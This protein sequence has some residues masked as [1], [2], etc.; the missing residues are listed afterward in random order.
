MVQ[1]QFTCVLLSWFF[2]KV[3]CHKLPHIGPFRWLQTK[4]RWAKVS[5]TGKYSQS[6]LIW[7]KT[8]FL[9]CW[10]PTIWG[11]SNIP[12]LKDILLLTGPLTTLMHWWGMDFLAR[13]A[14]FEAILVDEV[15]QAFSITWPLWVANVDGL[16][17]KELVEE[18]HD[19]MFWCIFY[20]IRYML[21]KSM[22]I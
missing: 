10:P 5:H 1:G 17:W 16:R 11:T 3:V 6:F 4:R 13:L 21:E 20:V 15:A 7:N 19:D 9:K 12:G 2:R 22:L 8:T 14:N 18:G